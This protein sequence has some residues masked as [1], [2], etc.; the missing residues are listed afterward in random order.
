LK[1]KPTKKYHIPII[2]CPCGEKNVPLTYK[3]PFV[4]PSKP[5]VKIW[6]YYCPF[7]ERVPEEEDEIKGYASIEELRSW[8]WEIVKEG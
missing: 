1:K 7:C 8:G 6:V 3:G 4:N 5:G 2:D